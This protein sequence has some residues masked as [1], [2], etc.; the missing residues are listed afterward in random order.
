IES[1]GRGMPTLRDLLRI[2][3]NIVVEERVCTNSRFARRFRAR[4]WELGEVFAGE[5]GRA[6]FQELLD[7]PSNLKMGPESERQ[8]G[9]LRRWLRAEEVRRTFALVRH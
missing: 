3:N 7:G 6:C 4:F 1:G 2:H 5:H 8:F 9:Q